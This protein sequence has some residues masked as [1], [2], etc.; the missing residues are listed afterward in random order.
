MVIAILRLSGEAGDVMKPPKLHA[1]IFLLL[2][3]ISHRT[4][5]Y[6]SLSLQSL[7][8]MA[9][10]HGIEPFAFEPMREENR[11]SSDNDS[12]SCEDDFRLDPSVNLSG[13]IE[14]R[15]S[16]D[17]ATWCICYGCS[18][19]NL[20]DM[21]CICC[22]EWSLLEGRFAENQT[23]IATHPDLSVLCF[24]TVVLTSMWPY[25]MQFKGIRGP[26]PR[27]LTNRYVYEYLVP[28][29]LNLIY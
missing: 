14:G 11:E 19:D 8:N 27:Q 15:S 18:T 10:G 17:V 2:S 7:R 22:K 5:F 6:S 9:S 1:A 26:I 25:V 13:S 24:D 28:V 12:T 29:T 16:R 23:C 3:A 4:H 20:T 21:E